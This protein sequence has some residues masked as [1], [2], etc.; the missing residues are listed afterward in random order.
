MRFTTH[1]VVMQCIATSPHADRENLAQAALRVHH[2]KPRVCLCV[3]GWLHFEGI[4][5]VIF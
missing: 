5:N 4:E 3:E 2:W 1:G